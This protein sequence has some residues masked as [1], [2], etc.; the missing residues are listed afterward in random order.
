MTPSPTPV[1]ALDKSI[2][3]LVA[4]LALAGGEL[5]VEIGLD[6]RTRYLVELRGRVRPFVNIRQVEILADLIEG[7]S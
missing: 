3:T 5:N 6:G 2:A 1:P 4:R 7:A